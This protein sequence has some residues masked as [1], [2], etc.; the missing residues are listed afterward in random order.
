MYKNLLFFSVTALAIGIC[1][2]GCAT[3]RTVSSA[4][5][6]SPKVYSGT[7]LDSLAIAGNNERIKAEFKVEPPEHPMLDLP[8]SVVLDTAVLPLTSSVALYE[9]VFE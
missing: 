5:I 3:L 7:R 1:L 2:S 9:V 4:G 6:D 8:F